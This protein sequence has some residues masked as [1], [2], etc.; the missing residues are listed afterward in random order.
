MDYEL[1]IKVGN[2]FSTAGGDENNSLTRDNAASYESPHASLSR[3]TVSYPIRVR[4][5]R[6]AVTSAKSDT[7]RLTKFRIP[8]TEHSLSKD[9]TP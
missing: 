6:D 8:R 3:L 7:K 1:A 2:V 9:V 4:E 5:T